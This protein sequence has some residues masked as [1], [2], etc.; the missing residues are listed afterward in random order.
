MEYRYEFLFPN[1][2]KQ[3]IEQMPVAFVPTGLLEWHANHLPLGQDALKAHGICVNAAE[4]LGG[5]VVLPPNYFGAP[6]YSTY[7]G[8]LTFSEKTLTP[9][10]LEYFEQL[11]KIGFKL[12]VLLTGHYGYVQVDFIKGVARQFRKLHPDVGIIAIPEYEGILIDGE[13]PNDHAGKWETSMFWHLCPQHTRMDEYDTIIDDMKTYTNAPLDYYNE[14]AHWDFGYDVREASSPAL[15]KRVIDAITD[16][17][18]QDI[19]TFMCNIS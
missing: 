12:I 15:G 8:T 10:F 9:L 4:K 11:K 18:V 2:L 3:C 7:L 19:N 13:Q 1:E 14:N 5:G 17:L 6:G 16:K